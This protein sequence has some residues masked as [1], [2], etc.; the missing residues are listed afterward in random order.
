MRGLPSL[1]IH[2]NQVDIVSAPDIVLYSF[3]TAQRVLD[4]W[5]SVECLLF[6]FLC[7]TASTIVD[8]NWLSTSLWPDV[9]YG[10][11]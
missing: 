9:S 5:K 3:Q 11:A 2:L 6:C 1:C 8:Y 10:M 7:R 4:T